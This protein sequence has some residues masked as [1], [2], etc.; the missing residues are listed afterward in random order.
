[1]NPQ[2]D[3]IDELNNCNATGDY[4]VDHDGESQPTRAVGDEKRTTPLM[5]RS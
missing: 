3:L 5:N 1:M 4:V 2:G